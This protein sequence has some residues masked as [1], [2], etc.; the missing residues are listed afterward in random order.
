M[1]KPIVSV[2]RLNQSRLKV[3]LSW[4]GITNFAFLQYRTNIP[5]D[6]KSSI[7]LLVCKK[8]ILENCLNFT[9]KHLYRGLFFN[10]VAGFQ[11]APLLNRDSGTSVFL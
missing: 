3:K 2:I 9:K 10:K 11:P 8:G 6:S 5:G 7:I 4:N 1:F